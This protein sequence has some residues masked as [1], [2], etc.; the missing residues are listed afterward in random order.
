MFFQRFADFGAGVFQFY[1]RF[2]DFVY[3][4]AL[5][6]LLPWNTRMMPPL[7]ISPKLAQLCP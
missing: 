4:S 1:T 2:S 7:Q 5:A 6:R 3:S